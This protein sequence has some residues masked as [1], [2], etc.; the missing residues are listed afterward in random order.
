MGVMTNSRPTILCIASFF[1]GND[2][3][4]ECKRLGA[5]VVLLTREKLLRDDWARDS[6][7]DLI[8]IPGKTSVQSYLAA[9]TYVARKRRVVR[10]VALEEY[11]IVTAAHIREHLCVSGLGA[12]IARS[13]QDKLAMRAKAREVTIPQP[14]FV[15]VVNYDVLD[16]FMKQTSSPW[17][18]KPR[19]GA[20]SMGMK[21]L[22]DPEAVWR[23]I[24]DLDARAPLHERSDFHLLEQFIPGDVY[25]VNSLV[26][27]GKVLFASVERYGLPPFEVAHSG[28]VPISY[29]VKYGSPEQRALLA[30]NKKLLKGFG[31]ELGVTHAEFIRPAGS[32]QRGEQFIFLE[33]AAR[34]G[35]AYTADTIAA[36]TG[37]NLWCEWAKIELATPERPYIP[38]PIR[39]EYGGIALSLAEQ[40]NPS[41]SDYDDPEIVY[42]VQKPWHV[43]LIVRSPD[44][45]RVVNLL[46]EYARRFREDF[47]AVAPAEERAEQYL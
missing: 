33:V 11:D 30:L 25:H 31:F 27:G 21:K 41:T 5:D 2:F 20:S 44:Q 22:H 17:M 34:V 19:I 3:I 43:G 10:V 6:L 39:K 16:E 45:E 47:T 9:A 7:D 37:I 18:L 36:A 13:F 42:R 35:G 14:E 15:P 46:T 40:E 32:A 23:A 29:F 38:P 12:T 24:G 4:R 8:A 1:K 26:A 28:G